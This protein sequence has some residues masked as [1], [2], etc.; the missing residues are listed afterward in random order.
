MAFSILPLLLTPD[1]DIAPEGRYH[2]KADYK[3]SIKKRTYTFIPI[4][5]Y[6]P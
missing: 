6:L 5:N 1:L 2:S 4:M 3:G